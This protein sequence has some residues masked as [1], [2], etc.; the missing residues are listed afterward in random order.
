VIAIV[1]VVT[2]FTAILLIA[3][4]YR[5]ILS[6]INTLSTAANR[7]SNGD[8]DFTLTD[9]KN[10]IGSIYDDFENMRVQLKEL[11]EKTD[12]NGKM[13]FQNATIELKEEEILFSTGEKDFI[14][15]RTEKEN[16]KDKS[17]G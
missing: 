9:K 11:I 8:Y 6:P 3:W 5:S 16:D 17:R 1:L 10:Q 12:K 14:I 13:S 4:I 2:F 15:K 7:I